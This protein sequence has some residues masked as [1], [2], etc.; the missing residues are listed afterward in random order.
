MEAAIA[1]GITNLAITRPEKEKCNL[2]PTDPTGAVD[3][4]DG[5]AE[6]QRNT[7]VA[8]TVNEGHCAIDK[9]NILPAGSRRERR[10]NTFLHDEMVG[11][12]IE[13]D[14]EAK[15][16]LRS[17]TET[18]LEGTTE[19]TETANTETGEAGDALGDFVNSTDG[20][21]QSEEWVMTSEESAT[22]DAELQD[23]LSTIHPELL[24]LLQEGHDPMEIIG[25]EQDMEDMLGKV[26]SMAAVQKIPENCKLLIDG[27]TFGHMYGK[28]VH[29]LLQ[30]RRKLPRPKPIM[31]ASGISY[32]HE[33]ADLHLGN[34]ALTGGYVNDHMDTTLVSEGVL[35]SEGWQFLGA[36][37]KKLCM[38]PEGNFV[39]E[40]HGNL[41]FWPTKQ[42]DSAARVLVVDTEPHLNSIV[43]LN[44]LAPIQQTLQRAIATPVE[45][46][47][48]HP[49]CPVWHCWSSDNSEE[50]KEARREFLDTAKALNWPGL[51]TDSDEE[52]TANEDYCSYLR[53]M[54]EDFYSMPD[55]VAV[56]TRTGA[57]KAP[58]EPVC[59]EKAVTETVCSEKPSGE[60]TAASP[61]HETPKESTVPGLTVP[62]T[63]EAQLELAN[64]IRCGH[65]TPMPTGKGH[66]H[67]EACK[68]GLMQN[69]PAFHVSRT[70]K[71]DKLETMNV[72]LLDMT[73]P[74]CNGDRYNVTMVVNKSRLGMSAGQARKDSATT[75]KTIT[76]TIAYIEAKTD[77]GNKRK[78]KIECLAHDPGPEFAGALPEAL[79]AAKI[80]DRCG[81]VDR[82]QDN[83][84]VENRNKRLQ[85][86]ATAMAI[87]AMGQNVD[88]YS[89]EAGCQLIRYANHIINHTCISEE[90]KLAK[91][92]AYQ[93][94]FDCSDTLD[95]AYGIK[96]HTWGELCYVYVIKSKRKNKLAAKAIRA[97]WNGP[98]IG[99]AHSHSAIPI[100]REG[101]KW[102]LGKPIH[103]AKVIV[104]DGFFPLAMD[105]TTKMPI[106]PGMEVQD[107]ASDAGSDTGS[108]STDSDPEEDEGGSET[109]E[110]AKVVRH[111]LLGDDGMEYKVRFKGYTAKDDLYYHESKCKS[112]M[113]LVCKYWMDKALAL[114]T[115]SVDSDQSL[116]HEPD[117]PAQ[118]E[119]YCS[120][121][122]VKS[123]EE[124]KS[125]GQDFI[126]IKGQYTSNA[127]LTDPQRPSGTVADTRDMVHWV[128]EYDDT[129]QPL[130]ATTMW[131]ER[132]HTSD[133]G[134]A[135]QGGY[136]YQDTPPNLQ[137][138]LP[139]RLPELQV[140]MT[141]ETNTGIES[142]YH[143]NIA[144]F[145]GQEMAIE[146]GAVELKVNE[147]LSPENKEEFRAAHE[148]EIAQM[149]KRRFVRPDSEDAKS[150]MY[151][152]IDQ[153]TEQEKRKALP[154]RLA[155]T[156]KRLALDDSE[157]K[158]G[159][160]KA[161]LIAKD[162]KVIN[163]R[164]PRETYAA[165]PSVDGFRLMVASCNVDQGDELSSTD[166]ETAYLQS[167]KWKDGRLVLIVYKDPFTDELVYEWLSGVIYGMQS[168][169]FDWKDTLSHYLTSELKFYEVANM[170]SMY[171]HSDKKITISCHVDD[172]LTLTR[173]SKGKEWFYNR[174]EADFDVKGTT[175][176]A[177]D[178]P[179]DYLSIRIAISKTG[180]ISLD[181]QVKIVS[182]L[183]EKG[184]LDCN[185]AS[186]P[187][188]KAKLQLIYANKAADKKQNE[189]DQKL[190]EKYLVEAQ[191]LAQTTHP[192]LST[193]VSML[194]SVKN[195][196]GSLQA[197]KHLFR[198]L[199][200][201]Q[202]FALVKRNGNYEGFNGYSDA[203]WAGLYDLSGGIELRSRTGLVVYYNGMPVTWGSY[204]QQCRS[205]DR[206]TGKDYCD[207]LIA[208][209]S[210]ESETHAGADAG[211][212]ALHLKY[213][214][215]ELEI[216][217]PIKMPVGVD[218]GAALGFIHNTGGVSRLKHINLRQAWVK[219]L[220]DPYQLDFYKILGTDNPA[221]LFTKIQALPAFKE[222]EARLM[223]E[224]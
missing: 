91:Q 72:D 27:G 103:S 50:A 53:E 123:P 131:L 62:S 101:E 37:N 102:K 63:K 40:R 207:E 205:T 89:E 219:A 1:A 97:I 100:S 198:Y 46:I 217:V 153:L 200:G 173:D 88:T 126:G 164:D 47:R 160:A 188:Q 49:V 29:H 58:S 161:R 90:Q 116:Q 41:H 192:V 39:A 117:Q 7:A 17:D 84:V 5:H 120:L 107:P 14:E 150:H 66:L 129:Q 2:V 11:A 112:F 170:L 148:K 32:V 158:Q 151:K 141:T 156:R 132:N 168:G 163:K 201:K 94:Q 204:F 43:N 179:L 78:Y 21:D 224:V 157:S 118:H 130:C 180:D 26:Q 134:D 3:D 28:N 167:T 133:T 176:L 213:I 31:T 36:G 56:N 124:N 104:V 218:A 42:S 122:T 159:T 93:E 181:N 140:M 193:A 92:T 76:S 111:H 221:D 45:T 128:S 16:M 65:A 96:I 51:D 196:E 135:V 203:D 214:A 194:S 79:A 13:N 172:P 68:K 34:Y 149:A 197:L 25:M 190:T 110:V 125:P 61:V 22:A 77:P 209:S 69:K 52:E 73:N 138:T 154:C 139:T 18:D 67:C 208:Q 20:S 19:S 57:G 80:V 15:A 223:Q 195:Y 171:H 30:N 44:D 54:Y 98:N 143:R 95:T 222:G 23:L 191:W 185:P 113:P 105:C 166:F 177:S 182:Y 155:Y 24:H 71:E 142:E 8:Q 147:I 162:L 144:M 206:K 119:P 108:D 109:Y 83:A 212:E 137:S 60:E 216:P 186:E 6:P 169:A 136:Q 4:S 215:E 175:T 33:M 10:A 99:N 64:H 178:T 81:E 55:F 86:I 70:A 146:V 87:T 85:N 74:D 75:T 187:L 127:T 145:L 174:L 48:A 184:L 189:A 12:L 152:P 106:P 9:S 38:T 82:H 59:S 114:P 121:T 115:M 210:A 220:R 211:K 199:K 202:R 183:T 35:Q 165:T